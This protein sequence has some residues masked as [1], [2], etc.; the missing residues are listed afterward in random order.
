MC[1]LGGGC[2]GSKTEF[3]CFVVCCVAI[4]RTSIFPLFPP[5]RKKEWGDWEEGFCSGRALRSRLD[6]F[7]G[8]PAFLGL[9]GCYCV[10]L[11]SPLADHAFAPEFWYGFAA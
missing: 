10:P 11:V 1:L 2:R 8:S 4:V 7:V 9:L 3:L 5:Q 6:R